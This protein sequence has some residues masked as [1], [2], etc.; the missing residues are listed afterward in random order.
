MLLPLSI[1]ITTFNRK[2]LLERCIKSILQQ[3]Y[4]NL[5]II[6][7][8]DHSTDGTK[9]Y[10]NKKYPFITYIYQDKNQGPS[11]ARN[12]G[13]KKAKN[14]FVIIMDDDETLIDN[15]LVKISTCLRANNELNFPV[16]NF[17]RSNAKLDFDDHL[18]VVSFEDLVNENISGDFLHVINKNLFLKNGYSFPPYHIGAESLLWYRIALDYGIPIFNIEVCYVHTDAENRLT[19]YENQ[20]KNAHEF[21]CY[22]NEIIYLFGE[23]I[24]KVNKNFLIKKYLGA[25]IYNIFARKKKKALASYF[26]IIKRDKKYIILAM[27]FLVPNKILRFLF[28]S[29]RNR[30]E[31][32]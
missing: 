11:V 21:A 23:Y 5:E 25:L 7:I 13:I 27:L 30:K 10:I 12:L 2:V 3:N 6:I 22:Q 32:R 1:V 4:D 26:E 24:E 19:N 29:Y 9:E 31:K 8:D 20:I 17:L 18:K 16:F 15:S 28:L 14:D